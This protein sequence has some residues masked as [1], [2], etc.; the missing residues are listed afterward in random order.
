VVYEGV[1]SEGNAVSPDD[2][3]EALEGLYRD[4]AKMRHVATACY[5]RV[6][7][8]EY[9]WDNI[10]RKWSSLFSELS[11]TPQEREI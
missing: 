9:Q 1:L 8:P 11:L 2:V 7:R 5:Q 10:G 6:S 4:R 3:A